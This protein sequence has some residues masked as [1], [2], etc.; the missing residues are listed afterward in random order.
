[1]WLHQSLFASQDLLD[2]S[3]RMEYFWII[4]GIYIYVR[5]SSVIL[6]HQQSFCVSLTMSWFSHW[7]N[8]TIPGH[9]WWLS[10]LSWPLSLV[11]WCPLVFSGENCTAPYNVR[12][13]TN[14]LM[15][16]ESDYNPIR[17]FL[18]SEGFDRLCKTL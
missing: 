4:F 12:S 1:M 16:H 8:K 13:L 18:F 5:N 7:R 2:P 17:W 11:K 14:F 9:S 3:V 15:N 10:L 6:H